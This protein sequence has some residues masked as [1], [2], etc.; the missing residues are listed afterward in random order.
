MKVCLKPI[1][2]SLSC[3]ISISAYMVTSSSSVSSKISASSTSGSMSK[4]FSTMKNSKKS[5][6]FEMNT[7]R[8]WSTKTRNIKP[9]SKISRHKRDIDKIT[10]HRYILK[11]LCA[12]MKINWSKRLQAKRISRS[13]CGLSCSQMI[14]QKFWKIMRQ[15]RRLKSMVRTGKARKNKTGRHCRTSLKVKSNIL[16]KCMRQSWAKKKKLKKSKIKEVWEILKVTLL[17]SSSHD[18]LNPSKVTLQSI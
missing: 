17:M 12:L 11:S 16:V 6:E 5:Q 14:S 4:L 1:I 10:K 13:R 2:W 3:V 15:K 18:Q 9:N 8:K 7:D